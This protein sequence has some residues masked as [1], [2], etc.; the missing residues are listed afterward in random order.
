MVLGDCMKNLDGGWVGM[1][2]GEGEEVLKGGVKV[3]GDDVGGG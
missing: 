1:L 3:C 2:L